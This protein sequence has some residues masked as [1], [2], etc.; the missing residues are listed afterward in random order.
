MP[1]EQPQEKQEKPKKIKPRSQNLVPGLVHWVRNAKGEVA[2]LIH[3]SG[4]LEMHDTLIID[5]VLC[6]PRQDIPFEMPDE[7]I[8]YKKYTYD[9]AKLLNDI[10][11]FIKDHVEMPDEKHYLI[12]ALWVLHTYCMEKVETSGIMYFHG[13]KQCGKSRTGIILSKLA[14]RCIFLSFVKAEQIY[15]LRDSFK[16]TMLIDEIRLL[17]RDGNHELADILKSRYKE[18]CIVP[19]CNMEKKVKDDQMDFFKIWGPTVLTTSEKLGD[20]I[21]DRSFEFLM[22]KKTRKLA[23]KNINNKEAARLRD[24]LILFRNY[25]INKDFPPF[26]SDYEDRLA[27]IIDPLYQMLLICDPR[28]EMIETFKA[29]VVE[30]DIERKEKEFVGP[31]ADLFKKILLLI[32]PRENKDFTTKEMVA[33]MNKGKKDNDPYKYK[34]TTIG[35]MIHLIGFQRVRVGVNRSHGWNGNDPALINSL[36]ERY[37]VP[38]DFEKNTSPEFPF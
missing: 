16:P 19:R 12:M 31:K 11:I 23:H 7:S 38:P 2:Y 35:E 28:P 8:L 1:D 20:F 29:F 36:R 6:H 14:F 15:R 9:P 25:W 34:E 37:G 27:E 24:E 4:V 30:I 32:Y 18:T 33:E 17:G 10:S 21:D 5:D 13:Q 22:K 3:N 26:E